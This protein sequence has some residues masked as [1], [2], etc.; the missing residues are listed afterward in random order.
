MRQKILE[1]TF[2]MCGITNIDECEPTDPEATIDGLVVFRA[3]WDKDRTFWFTVDKREMFYISLNGVDV[4]DKDKGGFLININDVHVPV[5]DVDIETFLMLQDVAAVE[6]DK[7][8]KYP[9]SA[10]YDAW[11]IAREDDKYMIQCEVQA[12]NALKI[13]EWLVCKVWFDNTNK[14]FLIEGVSIDGTRVK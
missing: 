12:Q 8:L 7:Y 1:K 11:A 5:S 13:K 4:F 6:I 9:N 14:D 3:V 2:I 10:Y